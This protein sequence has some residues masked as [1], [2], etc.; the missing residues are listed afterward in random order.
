MDALRFRHDGRRSDCRQVSAGQLCERPR[1]LTPADACF[2]LLRI[3]R[4]SDPAV[5]VFWYAS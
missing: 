1:V 5:R 4:S 3:S 2:L